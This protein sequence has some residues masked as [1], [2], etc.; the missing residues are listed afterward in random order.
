MQE[1]DTLIWISGAT[2][3]LGQGIASTVP[4]PAAR[5]INL[6]RRDHPDFETVRIDLTKPDSWAA[7][8]ESFQKEL[9]NFK[10]KRAIF[11]HN[12]FYQEQFA[13][14][15][16]DELDPTMYRDEA[17]A[18]GVAPQLLGHMFLKEAKPAYESGLVMIT[19]AGARVP[20]EG[21]AAYCAAK[22]AVEMWVRTVRTE[23]KRRGRENLWVMAIRPGFVDTPA[24]HKT[25]TADIKSYPLG[26]QIAKQ[27][28]TREG[29]MT[30]VEAGKG[31]WSMIPP[32]EDKSIWLQGEL[33]VVERP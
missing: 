33:V 26:P 27:L 18:N 16:S 19:S 2:Q 31:I 8:G 13:F 22:A 30:P 24:V 32:E 12:A 11:I 17:I 3:G 28:E 10:G 9:K 1:P 23:I 6:S 20:F 15:G 21:N 29:I 7:A 4:Y 5:I 14:V 25:L